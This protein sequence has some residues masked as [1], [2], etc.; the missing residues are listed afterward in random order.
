ERRELEL[1]AKNV[2]KNKWT[3]ERLWDEYRK[4]NPNL[5]GIATDKNRFEKYLK[6]SIGKKEPKELIPLDVA[7]L[8]I[9]LLKKKAPATVRNILELLRRKRLQQFEIY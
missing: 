7:R 8:K 1:A 2:E 5:K 6:G 9:R 3:I 4:F